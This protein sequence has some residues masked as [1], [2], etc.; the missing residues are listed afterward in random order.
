MNERSPSGKQRL[1]D[2]IR[3]AMASAILE[4]G[5]AVFAE[6]GLHAARMEDI[7]GRA[8]VAVGTLYNYFADRNALLCALVDSRRDELLQRFDQ[9]LA[10]TEQQPFRKQLEV[11]VMAVFQHFQSHL[12]FIVILMEAEGAHLTTA[13]PRDSVRALYARCQTLVTRG[14]QSGDLKNDALLDYAAMLNGCLRAVFARGHLFGDPIDP[15]EEQAA[16]LV[17]FFLRGAGRS[18]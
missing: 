13:K 10:A 6:Q 4:A 17:E 9:A 5:E 7:A 14:I 1:R 2:K 16:A 11:F 12:P 15:S 8:G 3:R 18:D